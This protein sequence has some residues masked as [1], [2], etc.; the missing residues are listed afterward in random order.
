[1][2]E[3]EIPSPQ[4]LKAQHPLTGPMK[5]Q[6]ATFRRSARAILSGEDPR[7]VVILGPCSIHNIEGAYA[8]AEFLAELQ[9]R[10]SHALF[11]VMRTH[12]EKPRTRLGWK[13]FV[14]DPHLDKSNQMADGLALSRTLLLELLKMGVPTAMELLEPMTFPYFSDLITWGTIGARTVSSQPHRE[15]ASL[16]HFPVGM[17][18]SIEGSI[19]AAINAMH[20]AEASHTFLHPDSRGQIAQI[21]SPGNPDTH[22]ILR[23]SESGSNFENFLES[24][25]ILEE[26]GLCPRVMIDCGHGNCHRDHNEQAALFKKLASV[27]SANLLGLMLESNIE[28]GRQSMHT[29]NISPHK[30]VTD[31]CVSATATADLI[32]HLAQSYQPLEHQRIHHL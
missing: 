9:E 10:T 31:P 27:R 11:L 18:N 28:S 30:S 13:G 20:T 32:D 25:H 7:L 16:A 17:K 26:E 2:I 15:L 6:I 23:G 29:P 12:I 14:S 5:K 4:F 8:Y 1:M 24:T 21:T 3:T 19:P 22:L